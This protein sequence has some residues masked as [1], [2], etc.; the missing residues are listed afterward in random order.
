MRLLPI[1]LILAGCPSPTPDATTT[2][3]PPPGEG[4]PGGTPGGD[5][6]AQPPGGDPGAAGTPGAPAGDPGQGAGGTAGGG[7]SL[8][9]LQVTPGNGVTLSGKVAYAGTAKGSIRIDVVQPKPDGGA[10]VLHAVQLDKF[11]DFSIEL[12]KDTGKVVLNAFVDANG[13][14]PTPGEPGGHTEEIDVKAAAVSGLSITLADTDPSAKG[15]DPNKK[16]MGPPD[17]AGV[18]PA[19]EAGGAPGGKPGE[20]GAPPAPPK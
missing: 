17:K 14:G 10:S 1:I 13:D 16:D 7:G 20:G 11:G 12:P 8:P 5:P 3:A 4:V 15:E 19:G 18:A 9:T 2:P 6:G